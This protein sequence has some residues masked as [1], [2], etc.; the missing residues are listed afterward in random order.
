MRSVYRCERT[1]V[2][3]T[4]TA[5][6]RRDEGDLRL[7]TSN[8]LAET[9]EKGEVAVD[10]VLRLEFPRRLDTLPGRRDLDQDALTLDA[11]RLVEGDEVLGLRLGCC[12]VEGQLGVNLGGD[13]AGNDRKDLLAELDKLNDDSISKSGSQQYG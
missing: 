1:R 8:S 9:E 4:Y 2:G 7:G 3:V 11:N 13:T 12:L 6:E 10:V 5:D